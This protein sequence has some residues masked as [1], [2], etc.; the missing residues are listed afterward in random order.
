ML[1]IIDQS[2]L[3]AT[4]AS[5]RRTFFKQAGTLLL[6]TGTASLGLLGVSNVAHGASTTSTILDTQAR[7]STWQA[8]ES[9]G[10]GLTSGPTV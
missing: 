4:T 3:D 6:T 8:W 2:S 1:K 7:P 10:G 9:L 5:N